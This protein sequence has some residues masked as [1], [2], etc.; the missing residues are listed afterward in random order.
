MDLVTILV[1]LI[2][3]TGIIFIRLTAERDSFDIFM[4]GLLLCLFS[5]LL[6]IVMSDKIHNEILYTKIKD[7]S[8]EEIKESPEYK[9][10]L[11]DF[12]YKD[13]KKK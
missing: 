9:K 2:V 10:W 13:L 8:F 12:E 11:I 6:T 4:L 5:I 7:N 1:I 3:L